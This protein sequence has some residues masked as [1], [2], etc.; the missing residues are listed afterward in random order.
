MDKTNIPEKYNAIDILE[1]NLAN[2]D[3]HSALYS[4]DSVMTFA[5]VSASVNQVSNALRGVGIGFGDSVG[6]LMPDTKEWVISFFGIIKT[7]AI[8]VCLNTELRSDEYCHIFQ[9]SRL[10]LLLVHESLLSIVDS[11]QTETPTLQRIIVVGESQSHSYTLFSN[12]IA[13]QSTQSA[14]ELTHCD[15]YCSLNYSSGT[16]GKPKGIY[17]SHKDYLL[18]AQLSGK[19]LFQIK[20]ADIT[21]SAAKLFFVY[22]LGAN[23]I[24]PWYAGA[25]ILLYQPPSRI[26]VGLLKTITRIRPTIFFAVPTVYAAILATEDFSTR[27]DLSSLRLC[28]SAGEALPASLW[29]AWKQQTGLEILDTIGCT[30][31]LH[32]FMANRVGEVRPGSSGKPSPGYEVKIVNDDGDEV[33]VGEI[34]NLIVKGKSTALF[35]LHQSEK[36]RDTFRGEWLFTG[37]KYYVD[38]DGYYWHCG[39]SDDMLKIGGVWVS[40]TEIEATLLNHSEI[41]ECAV[42]GQENDDGLIKPKA[43][44]CLK[45]NNLS[46]SHAELTKNI[47]QHCRKHLDSHKCPQWIEFTDEL[48]KTATGKIQRFKLRQG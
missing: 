11:I 18:I 16:T 40:P 13:K 19:E 8:A 41:L 2:R 24:F 31:T 47:L 33:A 23:L 36:S 44:V 12:W 9:D 22:G 25:S 42:I 39:R 4:A 45:G 32:T 30:E 14:T 27:F 29:S 48:P 1:G 26:A 43:F 35:Y 46:L 21:F 15:D 20:E 38:D 6:I 17:H 28:I 7:G 37:D 10:R 5:E 34:G 3:R